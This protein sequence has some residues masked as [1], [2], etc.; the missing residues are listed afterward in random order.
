MSSFSRIDT[1][2]MRR[3][4]ALAEKGRAGTHPNPMVGCIL[5][6]GGKIIGTGWH[7]KVGGPHA[8]P[9]ALKRAGRR[10]KGSTAYVTLEPCCYF[11]KTPPCTEALI[12][13]GVRRVVAAMKDPNPLV[14]GKGFGRLRR[15]GINVTQGVLRKDARELNRVFTH[16]IEKKRPYVILKAAASLDGRI[17]TSAKESKWIT[18][19]AARAESRRMRGEVDAI[20]VGIGTVLADDPRLTAPSGRHPLRV[21]LDTRLRAPKRAKVFRGPG[22]TLVATAARTNG[23][24]PGPN[25]SYLKLSRSKKGGLDLKGLLRALAKKG[26]ASLLVE[27]G[28]A[29]HTAFIEAGLVDEVRLFLSPRLIGGAGARS[30]FEG[31]GF[32]TLRA[33]LKLTDTKVRLVGEDILVTGRPR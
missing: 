24:M 28:S 16:W 18:S 22:R 21:I 27:G 17:E 31:A 1:R 7:K 32:R 2:Y 6:R 12:Q 23:C 29:V 14:A 11:G 33:S 26:V 4:L 5:V 25:V 10:A 3:A 19:S 13:A 20:L 9:Q 15:A 30:F 8:E